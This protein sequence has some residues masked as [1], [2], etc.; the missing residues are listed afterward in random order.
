MLINESNDC[1]FVDTQCAAADSSAHPYDFH[2]AIF[3]L[4]V[5]TDRQTDRQHR[6]VH[7]ISYLIRF[8][9]P[10]HSHSPVRSFIFYNSVYANILHFE[11]KLRR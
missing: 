5:S 2:L 6:L 11:K 3:A 10:S 4:S 7:I 8:F 9:S 1:Y